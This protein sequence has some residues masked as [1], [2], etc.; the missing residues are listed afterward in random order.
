MSRMGSV[1]G[2]GGG[3]A[4]LGGHLDNVVVVDGLV[5]VMMVVKG[6]RRG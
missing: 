6:E 1:T 4:C 2:C 3:I 5:M